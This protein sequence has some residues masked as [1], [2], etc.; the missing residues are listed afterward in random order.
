MTT[1]VG[2][3]FQQYARDYDGSLVATLWERKSGTKE[4]FT[5]RALY[6]CIY[7]SLT[8]FILLF[9]VLLLAVSV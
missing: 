1:R 6:P 7:L 5:Y 3:D 8:T 2:A 4:T 9:D